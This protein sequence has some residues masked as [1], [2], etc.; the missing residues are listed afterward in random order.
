MYGDIIVDKNKPCRKALIDN[1]L[2]KKVSVDGN[3]I[4]KEF[5]LKPGPL[6][7]AYLDSLMLEAFSNPEKYMDKNECLNF[8]ANKD[9]FENT[10]KRLSEIL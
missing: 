7:K 1:R 10:E 3:D 8:I 6:I 4:M 5:N 2:I 9:F